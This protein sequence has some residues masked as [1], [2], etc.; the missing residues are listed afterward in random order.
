MD[1]GKRLF[2]KVSSKSLEDHWLNLRI[3]IYLED[4]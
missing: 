2:A 4:F 1:A 3:E